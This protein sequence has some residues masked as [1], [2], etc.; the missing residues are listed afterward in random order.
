M[1][2]IYRIMLVLIPIGLGQAFRQLGLFGD[3]E[4]EAFEKLVV[5]L[6]VPVLVFFALYDMPLENLSAMPRMMGGFVLMTAALFCVGWLCSLAVEG[7]ERKAAVHAS[8]MLGNYGWMGLGVCGALLGDPGVVRVVFF[9]SLWWPVFYG[10]GVPVG[11]LH[12]HRRR[13]GVPWKRV[14]SVAA[15]TLVCLG[16]GLALNAGGVELPALVEKV[17]RPFDEMT[18]PLI[19]FSVGCML[20]VSRAGRHLRPALLVS[21]ATLLVGP[22]I[23]WGLGYVL[24]GGDV[25]AKVLIL[26]GAMP[27]ATLTPVL[28]ATIDLETDLVRVCIAMSTLL[29]LATL[30]VVAAVV[31]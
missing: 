15:P 21:A 25:T 3:E 10:F 8:V 18:V 4:G 29:S 1:S 31:V 12:A 5:R 24:G 11:L 17:F 13:E 20:K 27:V 14:V 7:P 30:P 28:G 16:A 6:C 9:I 26:E 19:L 22:F 23:G 2:A